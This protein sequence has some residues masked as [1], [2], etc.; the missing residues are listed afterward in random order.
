MI[1]TAGLSLSPARDYVPLP[2][3][4]SVRATTPRQFE[5]SP[6]SSA[7]RLRLP[8]LDFPN[9]QVGAGYW[10]GASASNGAVGGPPSNTLPTPPTTESD[11]FKPPSQ[12]RENSFNVAN[13]ALQQSGIGSTSEPP[14]GAGSGLTARR[15]AA[16]S[17]PSFELPPPQ[18]MPS[19]YLPY[20]STINSQPPSASV[21]VNSLSNLLTPPS[22]ISGD[23]HSPISG[24]GNGVSSAATNGLPPYTTSNYWPPGP[25][26]IPPFSAGIS[27]TPQQ[28]S[29]G[30]GS[31][32]SAFPPRPMFSP[33]GNPLGRNNSNSPT[34]SEGLPPPPP[35]DMGTLP[36][37]TNQMGLAA[38]AHL[39]TIGNDPA[40][41][42]AFMHTQT[43]QSSSTTTQPSP[44]RQVSD[45]LQRPVTTPSYFNPPP[46]Q[47]PSS[48]PQPNHYPSVFPTDSPVQ[49]S[50][51]GTVT[52]AARISPVSAHLPNLGSTPLPQ[53]N[54]FLRNYPQFSLPAMPGGLMGGPIMSN[55]HAPGNQM[56]MVGGI[57]GQGP[58]A[59]MM[60]TFNSGHSAHMQTM[61]GSSAATP[62]SERPFKCDQ[63]PQSFNRNHDLKRHKRIHLAVKPFP[64]AHCDK[65]F[66]RKDALKVS[67]CPVRPPSSITRRFFFFWFSPWSFG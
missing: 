29:W 5:A 51:I 52:Q 6:P 40:A 50:P 43:P 13:G 1:K 16:S 62:L 37:F 63:C 21:N 64:C 31:I 58:A 20:S 7:F 4:I 54:S 60:P 22:H 42:Q 48:T 19:R 18:P 27:T 55:L 12:T 15:P 11:V 56:A 23:S 14:G 28:Q 24:G 49:Q 45:Y 67:F 9:S 38:P 66:S 25:S 2:S 57:P 46:Q 34:A 44:P 53:T 41:T 39:P 3:L 33:S 30:Q 17:L 61:F 65:S 47:H 36:P 59:G 35:Y 32:S 10:S 26:G 8:S